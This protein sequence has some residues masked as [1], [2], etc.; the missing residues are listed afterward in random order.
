MTEA[1]SPLPDWI[2]QQGTDVVL[3][4]AVQP[5]SSTT[6]VVG[7]HDGML[8]VRLTAPPVDGAANA[9]LIAWCADALGVRKAAV[10][11]VSGQ[12]SRRKR[13]LVRDQHAASIVTRLAV[14]EN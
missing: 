11:I 8:R 3:S 10:S 6:G 7:V 14:P 13:L 12:S 1:R 2:Q 9:A 5:R 4:V